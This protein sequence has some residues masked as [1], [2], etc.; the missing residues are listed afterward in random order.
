MKI[1]ISPSILI[2]LAAVVWA[3]G[4]P[5]VRAAPPAGAASE[6]VMVVE[7]H[8]GKVLIA[9]GS[10][11]RRAIASLTK[12]ATGVVALDWAKAAGVEPDEVVAVVPQEAAMLGGPNPMGLKPGDRMSLRDAL[13]SA[14]LGSDNIAALAVADCVG[15]ELIRRRGRGRDPGGVFVAEM[16]NLAKAIGARDTRFTNPHGLG[17]DVRKHRSSAADLARLSIYAMRRPAFA[18]IVRQK[19]RTVFVQTLA[20]KHGF[21]VR[22]TNKLLGEAGVVGIKTGYT[23]AAGQ[24]LATCVER[25]P[26]V[27][28]GADGRK[29]VTKRRLIVIVLGSRDRFVRTRELIRSGW[30]VYDRWVGAGSPVRNARREILGVP[31]PK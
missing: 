17:V 21:K 28:E 18:F 13:Y 26:L 24:C 14:L 12:I 9:S 31:E 20:G 3:C 7:A 2:L 15:R 5:F 23:A 8:S 30:G 16:N 27:S 4:V 22:N 6:S 19:L 25:D 1:R 29:R 10:T 11:D